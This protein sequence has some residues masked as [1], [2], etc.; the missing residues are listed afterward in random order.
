[1]LL[2]FG[3]VV[4]VTSLLPKLRCDYEVAVDN[5]SRDDMCH[6]WAETFKWEHDLPYF[7]ASAMLIIEANL[8][9]EPLSDW[10]PLVGKN[11]PANLVVLTYGILRNKPSLF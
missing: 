7:L 11:L 1:M 3:H 5:V 2:L 4:K 9:M 6:Y 10:V 8:K